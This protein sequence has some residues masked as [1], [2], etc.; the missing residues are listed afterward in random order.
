MRLGAR[1]VGDR[2]EVYDLATGEAVEGVYKASVA[3]EAGG[4]MEVSVAFVVTP[5][6]GPSRPL[7]RSDFLDDD[8]DEEPTNPKVPRT[9]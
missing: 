6:A 3:H 5:Q 2:I 8:E 1:I 4:S 9:L 7:G